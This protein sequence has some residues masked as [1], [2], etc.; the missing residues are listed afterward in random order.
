MPFVG[1]RTK[2][3]SNPR[4]PDAWGVQQTRG[5]L[6]YWFFTGGR[7]YFIVLF[8]RGGKY[9]CDGIN[10]FRYNGTAVPEF[11]AGHEG[12]EDYRNWRM[13][14]G[15]ITKQIVVKNFT[16]SN[17]TDTFTSA[18]HG[19]NNDDPVRIRSLGGVL[20]AGLAANGLYY[21]INKT[22]NTFQLSETLAGSAIN[23]TD[24]GSGTLKVWKADAG[25][26]DPL[27]GKPQFF[28][29]LDLTFSNIFYIEGA[30]P[31]ALSADEEP[32]GFQFGLRCRKVADYDAD[33]N[34]LGNN[35][36]ANNA[37]VYSDILFNDLK[38]DTSRL[39][40]VSWFAFKE[41]C[42]KMVW[43]RGVPDAASPGTG[44]TGKYYNGTNFDNFVLTRLDSEVNFPVSYGAPATGV[45]ASYFSVI[46][47]GKIKARYTENYTFELFHDDGAKLWIDNNLIIDQWGLTNA[48]THYGSIAMTADALVNIRIEWQGNVA[49][50]VLILKWQSTSQSLEPVPTSKLYPLDSQ[51]KYAEAHLVFDG[52]MQGGA[53]LQEVMKRAPGWHDQDVNG[54]IKFLPPDRASV[55]TFLY[56][57]AAVGE[58]WNIAAKTFEAKPRDPSERINFRIHYFN[59]LDNDLLEEKWIEADRP[60][61]RERQGGLPT[62]TAPA[63]WGVMTRSLTKRVAEMEMKLFSDS[64]RE[65]NLRGQTDSYHVSKGDR[66][67]LAHIASGETVSTP[68]DCIVSAEGFAAGPGDEKSYVLLP[69]EFPL[70]TVEEV[71]E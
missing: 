52:A 50:W 64:D 12:D 55:H 53:A 37:R 58:R 57:P 70:V 32:N 67:K 15:T 41:K 21:I 8:C 20:P 26:D 36:S 28:P 49:P 42:D 14:P 6:F 60:A 56:D 63:R 13:H 35:F 33:G 69:V 22:T 40:F 39:D 38:K 51:V 23:I 7:T 27:Q 9:G 65:F 25:F 48:G 61:L 59:D 16:A 30:L 34:Y 31:T 10:F 1:R 19:Y 45:G 11:E 24:D 54:Q 17:S 44:L 4:L 5:R 2:D 68:I 18:A 71:E 62:E 66:V 29:G 46:L 43:D 3:E 47:E